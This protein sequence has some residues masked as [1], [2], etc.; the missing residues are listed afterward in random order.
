MI[1]A[2]RMTGRCCRLGMTLVELLLASSVTAL[3]ATAGASLL[4]AI[5]S[6]STETRDF[7][8]QRQVGH[9]ALDRMGRIIRE[10]RSVGYISTDKVA[11]WLNDANENEQVDLYEVG[12][13][14]YNSAKKAVT[15]R[16]FD[17]SGSPAPVNV[18]GTTLFASESAMTNA[19]NTYSAKEVV[20]AED[21]DSMKFLGYPNSVEARVVMSEFVM[22]VN[23]ETQTFHVA[24]SPRAPAEYLLVANTKV[25]GTT[26]SPLSR[27]KYIAMWNGSAAAISAEA[28]AK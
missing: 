23:G 6:A 9:Y 7:R 25:A 22:T 26:Q 19:L 2:R 15:Y 16:Y 14:E 20:L 18:V 3:T 27:R 4:Y 8:T 1:A 21:V 28:A 12:Q 11:L 24:A 13:I 17:T 5:S 10:A